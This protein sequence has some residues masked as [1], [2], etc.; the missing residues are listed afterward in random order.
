MQMGAKNDQEIIEWMAKNTFI[1]GESLYDRY[2]QVDEVLAGIQAQ[3]DANSEAFSLDRL[4]ATPTALY[5]KHHSL[6]TSYYYNYEGVCV[7][8]N[9]MPQPDHYCWQNEVDSESVVEE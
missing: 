6:S 2:P 8:W 3:A 1:D 9:N 5:Y 4:R 7:D